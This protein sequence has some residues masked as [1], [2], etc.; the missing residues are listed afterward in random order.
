MVQTDSDSWY[1]E[2]EREYRLFRVWKAMPF[3]FKGGAYDS[4]MMD[5]DDLKMVM[6]IRTQKELA[7]ILGV[8]EDTISLWNN[9]PV[10]DAFKDIDFHIWADPLAKD[11]VMAA[12]KAAIDGKVPAMQ[13]FLGLSTGYAERHVI[14]NPSADGVVEELQSLGKLIQ[15][16]PDE[17]N[18]IDPTTPVDNPVDTVDNGE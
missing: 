16:L 17:T 7:T 11:V 18:T 8:S 2:L 13:L 10:P 9:K 3:Q 14:D 4:D 6:S 1:P 15:S 12:Y 5:D